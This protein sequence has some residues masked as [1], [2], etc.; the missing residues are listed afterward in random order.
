MP[1]PITFFVPGA[2]RGK[3]RPRATMRGVRPALYTD[4]KTASYENL[5]RLAAMEAMK[6]DAPFD[7][8]IRLMVGIRFGIPAS[9][10]K[11]RKAQMLAGDILPTSRPDADNVAKAVLDALST[12]AFKDDAQV[13][14]LNIFKMYADTPGV[15]VTV[16][17][18]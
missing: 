3:G 4:A 14:I 15:Q 13:V 2:P 6:G 17:R 9:A 1:L 8:A 7:G 16:G 12:V 10:S 5:V 11:V 18:A